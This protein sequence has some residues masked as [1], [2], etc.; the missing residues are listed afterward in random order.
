MARLLLQ[1]QHARLV[2]Q[3]GDQPGHPQLEGGGES[4]P[5]P[6]AGLLLDGAQGGGAGDVQQAEDHQAQRVEGPEA[7]PLQGGGKGGHP[8]RAG[9]RTVHADGNDA[10]F[11]VRLF[12][13]R[14]DQHQQ[15]N[16]Y[17]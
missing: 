12:I 1:D 11:D 10:V 3:E 16:Q 13:E 14:T 8:R 6:A 4:H 2:D 7:D 15:G 17:R 5:G 9:G